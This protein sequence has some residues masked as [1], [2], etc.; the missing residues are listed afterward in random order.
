MSAIQ[1]G[2]VY[3]TKKVGQGNLSV[4]SPEKTVFSTEKT[5]FSTEKTVFSTEKTV[6]STEKTVF[7][8]EKTVFSTEKTVFSTEKTVFSTE[9]TV[10]STEKTVFHAYSTFIAIIPCAHES[11]RLF[12]PTGF[13]NWNSKRLKPGDRKSRQEVAWNQSFIRFVFSFIVV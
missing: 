1:K 12:L 10:F 5:V 11:W 8:T 13:D 6:F 4:C 2:V 9:K 7:S 3:S